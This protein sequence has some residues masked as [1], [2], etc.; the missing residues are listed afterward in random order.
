[1]TTPSDHLNEDQLICLVVDPNDLPHWARGHLNECGFCQ[2]NQGQLEKE[3]AELGRLAEFYAPAPRKKRYPAVQV[4][5]HWGGRTFLRLGW[6]RLAMAGALT[7][8]LIAITLFWRMPG[9]EALDMRKVPTLADIMD[10]PPLVEDI[11]PSEDTHLTEIIQEV[12]YDANGCLD[13]DF[14]EF[15]APFKLDPGSDSETS[16]DDGGERRQTS[17]IFKTTYC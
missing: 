17:A 15:V 2:A 12:A 1:M 7:M 5:G 9:N 3:L 4:P 13:D 16:D 6:A 14:V 10:D 11:L 8:I